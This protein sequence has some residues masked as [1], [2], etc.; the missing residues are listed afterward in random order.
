M[1]QMAL[2]LALTAA[3]ACSDAFDPVPPGKQ[4]SII[5][6]G[7]PAGFPSGIVV[8]DTVGAGLVTVRYHSY[9]SSS[10]NRPDGEDVAASDGAVTIIAYDKFVSPTVACTADFGVFPR[11]VLVALQPGTV[12]IRVRGKRLGADA[13]TVELRKTVVVRAAIAQPV[14]PRSPPGG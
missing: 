11:D 6:A 1:R 12:Q 2:I 4:L 5:D 8:P 10:C 3:S 9:G 13:P 7:S 14:S